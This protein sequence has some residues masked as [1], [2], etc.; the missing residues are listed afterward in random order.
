[1]INVTV[2]QIKAFVAVAQTQSFAEAGALVHLSQP[3]LS[4]AIRNLEEAV[5]GRLLARSTRRL[6]L[7][8]EGAAFLPV[9]QRLLGDWDSALQD[10]HNLFAM[11]RGKMTLAAMPSFASNQLPQIV[12]RYRQRYPDVNV[13]VQDVVA[14]SVVEMVRSGRVEIGVTFDPDDSNDLVFQPLFADRFVAVLPPASPLVARS[15]VTWRALQASSFLALQ[16]P[17]G[18]RALIDRTIADS[19]IHLPVELEAHQLATIGRMV[20]TGLGVS[21]VP[22]L[23]VKQMEEMGAVCRPL[24]GPAVSRRV[25]VITRCRYPLSQAAQAML[26]ILLE[27]FG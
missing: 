10:L 5:G 3:A 16:R 25:G 27:W 13:A 20:A 18:I 4:I 12:E 14:E 9:A 15:R 23:C 7:T 19:G 1:M 6:S 24:T 17:S 26:E 22:A 21:A 2:K 8:P 11:R